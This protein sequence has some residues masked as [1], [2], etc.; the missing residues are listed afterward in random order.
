MDQPARPPGTERGRR[1]V[2]H[3][4]SCLINV[5]RFRDRSSSPALS[6]QPRAW[7]YATRNRSVSSTVASSSA[8]T[9]EYNAAAKPTRTASLSAVMLSQ[10][11]TTSSASCGRFQHVKPQLRANSAELA[12]GTSERLASRSQ[13]ALLASRQRRRPTRKPPGSRTLA[14]GG[15]WSSR[16]R[17]LDGLGQRHSCAVLW[18]RLP[19]W[20]GLPLPGRRSA[21]VNKW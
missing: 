16:S 4:R 21:R 17:R 8:L 20:E 13:W 1:S 5:D 14:Q 15:G 12:S 18:G 10:S 9:V 6:S 11:C 19:F 7:Q 3:P 2:S